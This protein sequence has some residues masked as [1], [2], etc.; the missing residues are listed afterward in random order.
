MA[1]IC[2]ASTN[3]DKYKSECLAL[4]DKPE[5]KVTSSYGKLKYDF[6]KSDDFLFEKTMDKY[7]EYGIEI[8][9]FKTVGLTTV[10][11]SFDFDMEV[12]V[13][14]LSDGYK[15][16]YPSKIKTYL[17]YQ[18]PTIY[19]SNSL[20][21]NSCFYNVSLQHEKTHMEVY[22]CALDDFLPVYKRKIIG[23]IDEVGVLVMSK[24]SNTEKGVKMLNKE[25]VEKAKNIVNIWKGD[26]EREQSKFDTLEHYTLESRI[27]NELNL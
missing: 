1:K 6:S 8:S 4:I 19:I 16:A 18:V 24:K 10:T 9:S 13:V 17:G 12:G 22:I 11:V 2:F 5:I 27:C 20:E 25:Y 15:C 21:K 7:Q 3:I 23:L 14:S 26:V